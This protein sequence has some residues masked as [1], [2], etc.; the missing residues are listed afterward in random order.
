MKKIISISLFLMSFTVLAN[1]DAFLGTY[2]AK[3]GDGKAVVTKKIVTERTLFEPET[4]EYQVDIEREKDEISRSLILKPNS[5]N[6]ALLGETS[7]DCD[8]PDCHAFDLLEVE[9]KQ[10]KGKAQLKLSYEGYNTY[11]GE[12][13]VEKF[14]GEALFL[15]K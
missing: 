1:V 12:D 11:D 15:K 2:K 5:T 7:D 4:Y 8:N 13:T 14:N 6:T 10:L 9:I 3:D